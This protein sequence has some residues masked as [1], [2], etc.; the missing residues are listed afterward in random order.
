MKNKIF[1]GKRSKFSNPEAILKISEYGLAKVIK[2]EED[3]ILQEFIEFNKIQ[4]NITQLASLVKIIHQN[5]KGNDTLVHGDIGFYNTTLYKGVPK[6]YDYEHAHFGNAYIDLGRIIL[7]ACKNIKEIEIFFNE[8]CGGIPLNLELKEGFINFCNW[9][10]ITRSEK[11]IP[12]QQV[13]LIRKQRLEETS[14]DLLEILKA[15]KDEVQLK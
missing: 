8:Y 4:L 11:G 15:F 5:K 6:C 12:F 3:K 13:P 9:Q 7:R 1:I 14:G 2:I 10:N